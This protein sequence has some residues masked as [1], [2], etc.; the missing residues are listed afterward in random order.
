MIPGVFELL[1]IEAQPHQ[2]YPEGEQLVV[3]VGFAHDGAALG[4]GLGGDGEA[5]IDIGGHLSG[6]KGRIKA[7]PFNGAAIKSRV[8]I[9]RIIA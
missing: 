5:Q 6:V 1:T 7:P 4:D 3:A 9:K 8:K 2:P